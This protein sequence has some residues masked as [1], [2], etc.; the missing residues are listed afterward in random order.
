MNEQRVEIDV[1][2]S[3][4]KL[5]WTLGLIAASIVGIPVAFACAIGLLLA[6]MRPLSSEWWQLL[7][8]FPLYITCKGWTAIFDRWLDVIIPSRSGLGESH[9]SPAAFGQVDTS[10]RR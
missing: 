1:A 7:L 6:L 8:W 10:N 2:G 9:L 5:P 4:Q 3:G